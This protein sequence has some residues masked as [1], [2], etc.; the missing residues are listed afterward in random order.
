MNMGINAGCEYRLYDT[1]FGGI[2]DLS[3]A[4]ADRL[5]WK[6]HDYIVRARQ[7]GIGIYLMNEESKI[8][9]YIIYHAMLADIPILPVHD[10]FR[11][12]ARHEDW[13]RNIMV[14]AYRHFMG[15]DP[16]I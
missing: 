5:L 1:Q 6:H 15:Y 12:K 2:D 11:V 8:A 16:V 7:S 10:G 4:E 3:Y 14:E 13:L 9:Q